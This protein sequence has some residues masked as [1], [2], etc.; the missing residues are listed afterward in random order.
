[1][2]HALCLPAAEV[3]GSVYPQ[4]YVANVIKARPGKAGRKMRTLMAPIF[5]LGRVTLWVL[6][7]P[8]GLL[9]EEMAKQGKR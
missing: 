6:F 2:R 1:M 7:F 9:A 8:V 3:D 5:W 4:R